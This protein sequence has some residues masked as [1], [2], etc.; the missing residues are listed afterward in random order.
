MRA[1]FASLSERPDE[2]VVGGIGRFWRPGGAVCSGQPPAEFAAF[3]EPGFVKAAFDFRRPESRPD[4]LRLTTE[5]RIARHGRR[6][7]AGTSAA[8]GA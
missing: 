5:T 7:R 2:L 4:R 6:P 3:D 8:T 1:G